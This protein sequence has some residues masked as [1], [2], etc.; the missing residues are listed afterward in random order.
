ML[1]NSLYSRRYYY[2]SIIENIKSAIP[3]YTNL[4]TSYM[5]YNYLESIY[6]LN[7]GLWLLTSNM[8]DKDLNGQFEKIIDDL[9][10]EYKYTFDDEPI[11][12]FLKRIEMEDIFSFDSTTLDSLNFSILNL[13]FDNNLDRIYYNKYLNKALI[14]VFNKF[15]SYTIQFLNNDINN[16]PILS[17]IKSTRYKLNLNDY[18][19]LYYIF[20]MDLVNDV[21]YKISISDSLRHDTSLT[22]TTQTS[23][24]IKI[25]DLLKLDI[26]EK[27]IASVVI[28]LNYRYIN[29]LAEP[30]IQTPSSNEELEF[31][32]FNS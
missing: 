31:L 13:L 6:R 5:F 8:S 14:G 12:D 3:I 28:N 15:N 11:D 32:A 16:I 24:V 30:W 9:H 29:S 1:L 21:Y 22:Y 10:M 19:A 17:G 7:I 2:R 20:S 4:Q 23:S 26:V 27:R 25:E 18:T